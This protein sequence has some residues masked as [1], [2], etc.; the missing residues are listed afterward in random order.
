MKK[1][2]MF[3]VLFLSVT[4]VYAQQEVKTVVDA[5]VH[6]TEQLA[7]TVGKT[8]QQT[9]LQSSQAVAVT[10]AKIVNLPGMPL[11]QIQTDTP[12]ATQEV[13]SARLLLGSE[14]HRN[15]NLTESM[16]LYVP[17]AFTD[18]SKKEVFRGVR[19][20]NLAELENIVRNGMELDK[21]AY[22]GIYFGYG[23]STA[24]TYALPPWESTIYEGVYELDLTFPVLFQLPLASDFLVEN[25]ADYSRG[26]VVFHQTIP[27]HRFDNVMTFL[28]VNGKPGWYKAGLYNNKLLLTPVPAKEVPGF[29]D[30]L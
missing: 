7:R 25:P 10:L 19:L 22:D 9:T 28:E 20:E 1:L 6:S 16:H 23:P 4:V 21:T 3:G 13:L 5:S 15:I 8:L 18:L 2:L 14:L 30:S 29:V 26:Y 17:E 12:P 24:L 27:A 11:V